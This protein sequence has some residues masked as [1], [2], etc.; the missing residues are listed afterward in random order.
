MLGSSK[1]DGG[2]KS[3]VIK[4]VSLGVESLSNEIT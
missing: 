3:V 1:M 4:E 2:G